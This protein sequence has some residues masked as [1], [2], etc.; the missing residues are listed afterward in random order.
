MTLLG[1]QALPCSKVINGNAAK[2]AVCRL[3]PQPSAFAFG[4]TRLAQEPDEKQ[5]SQQNPV[6]PR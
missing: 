1:G 2:D 6:A 5:G 4:E 3:Q